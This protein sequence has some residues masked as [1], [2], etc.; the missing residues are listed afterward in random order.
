M[1]TERWS[2]NRVMVLL[3]TG[4]L[5]LLLI[6]IRYEHRKALGDEAAAWVPLVFTGFAV[7]CAITALIAWK[8]AGRSLLTAVFAASLF[9]GLAGVFFHSE[10]EVARVFSVLSARAVAPTETD[11]AQDR[12]RGF[13]GGRKIAA[14]EGLYRLV[15][16]HDGEGGEDE[17]APPVLAPL[18]FTGIGLMGLV[19]TSRRFRAED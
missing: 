19:A 18:A 9:V 14:G 1:M 5:L 15:D 17:A 13:P 16:S 6:E 7:L 4:G 10:G 11:R 2:L 8:P 3:L 12:K